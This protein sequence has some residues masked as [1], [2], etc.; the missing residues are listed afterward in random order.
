MKA[1]AASLPFTPVYAALVAV[2]NTKFP[3]VGALLC[4]R[5]V[6]Q[7]RKAYRRNDKVNLWNKRHTLKF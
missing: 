6:V 5:L 4:T 7:F 1:Q 2:V 3:Q